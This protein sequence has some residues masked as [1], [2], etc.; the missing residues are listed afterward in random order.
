[1]ADR[2]IEVYAAELTGWRSDV[3]TAAA[4]TIRAAA[5][6]AT[7]SIKWSQP[8]FELNGPFAYIKAFP[9]SVNVGFWRGAELT[10]PQEALEGGGDRMKHVTLRQT[11]DLD[12][13]QLAAWVREAV[14]LNAEKGNP[15]KRG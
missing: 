6:G 4:D 2:T 7:E 1:M 15:T 11:D 9:R 3:V 13:E 14:R 5:P 8:V 10:D 12:R